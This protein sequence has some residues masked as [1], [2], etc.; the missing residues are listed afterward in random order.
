VSPPLDIPSFGD[1][2]EW[3]FGSARGHFNGWTASQPP[4][5]TPDDLVLSNGGAALQY[6][7]R[8]FSSPEVVVGR[9]SQEDIG[10]GF[11][12]MIDGNSADY[13][14]LFCDM[15]QPREL[16]LAIVREIPTV[17]RG[18]FARVC[19]TYLGHR[20]SPCERNPDQNEANG[21]CYMW[22]DVFPVFSRT[23]NPHTRNEPDV[24]GHWEE[25]LALERT[26]LESLE[27]TLEIPHEAC[28]EGALHGLGH[29]AIYYPDEVRGIVDRF[30]DRSPAL[31]PELKEYALCAREGGVQ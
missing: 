12:H 4:D 9:F 1:W 17:Y 8:V 15:T 28:V 26:C 21:I 29:W 22:R 6:I 19:E 3:V 20:Q 18:V 27:R 30:L 2:V 10:N 13:A 24:R 5:P 14:H 23:R 11:S 25:H 31:S 16:R 7:G